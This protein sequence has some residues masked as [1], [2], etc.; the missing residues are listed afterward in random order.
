MLVKSTNSTNVLFNVGQN[1]KVDTAVFNK[2]HGHSDIM[3]I[4]LKDMK[5]VLQ[6]RNI[7]NVELNLLIK[8]T[9]NKLKQ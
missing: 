5:E 4:I 7:N 9:E 3:K 2:N 1:S 6:R 8:K